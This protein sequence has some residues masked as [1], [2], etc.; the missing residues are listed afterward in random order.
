MNSFLREHVEFGY[1]DLGRIRLHYASAGDGEELVILLHGFPE[2][3]YSWRHQI[4]ALSPYFTVVAPDLRGYNLSD[5]PEGVASYRIEEL[6]QDVSALIKHFGRDSAAVV[7]HDWGAAIAW[8]L[9][10]KEPDAVSKLAC[11]QVPPASVWKKNQTL[12]QYL[13]SWYMIFFQL[14]GIP[15]F[16]LR[17]SDFTPLARALKTTTAEKGSFSDEDVEKYKEAWSRDGALTASINYYR[18]NIMRRIF[19]ASDTPSK[20]KMPTLFI[21]GEKDHAVMPKTVEN[22][23]DAV[24]GDYSELRIPEAAH[25]VQVEASEKVSRAL[26]EFLRDE[27]AEESL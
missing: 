25:W 1:A 17:S 19:S 18:A 9:A 23:E 5:K 3:W 13:S 27:S 24:E 4:E 26:V 16:Y 12:S 6:C 2:F 22:V 14:P 7:G 10:E 20:I 11:L 8:A 15:E 21:Y